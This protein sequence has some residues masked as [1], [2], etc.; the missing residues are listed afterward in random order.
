MSIWCGSNLSP[1]PSLVASPLVPHPIHYY[2]LM[3]Q[4]KIRWFFIAIIAL[5]HC[6]RTIENFYYYEGGSADRENFGWVKNSKIDFSLA[7]NTIV[8]WTI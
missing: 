3:I 6:H 8:L 7:R 1:T 2:Y 4:K 5:L